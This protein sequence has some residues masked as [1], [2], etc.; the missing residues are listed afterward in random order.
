MADHQQRQRNAEDV[1]ASGG[2]MASSATRLRGGLPA[3]QRRCTAAARCGRRTSS[4]AAAAIAQGNG[5]ARRGSTSGSA[6]QRRGCGSGV[7]VTI[8]RLRR[9]RGFDGGAVN[10]AEQLRCGEWSDRS[11]IDEGC[12]STNFDDAMEHGVV[13]L[14]SE[15]WLLYLRYESVRAGRQVSRPRSG[16]VISHSHK[17]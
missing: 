2:G 17:G 9:W 15:S 12:D 1:P 10:G 13:H 11:L 4:D 16:S 3:R 14:A 8:M 6:W 7:G 5:A